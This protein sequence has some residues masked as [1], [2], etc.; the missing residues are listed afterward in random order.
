[1]R[2]DWVSNEM[3]AS[4]NRRDSAHWELVVQK[5]A[6]SQRL[7]ETPTVRNAGIE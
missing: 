3:I 1:M 4:A 2:R 5:S 7:P 6:N